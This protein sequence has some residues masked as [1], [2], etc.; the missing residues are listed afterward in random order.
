MWV[1]ISLVSFLLA[2]GAIATAFRR[3]GSY[4][5]FADELDRRWGFLL[6][7]DQDASAAVAPVW[8]GEF[9]TDQNDA[10]WLNMMRY[11]RERSLDFAYWPLN[12]EK[13]TNEGETYGLLMED[14]RSVRHTWKLKA[15]QALIT[16]P[17][18]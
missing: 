17:P 4:A 3:L 10:W 11:A 15:M 18:H 5:V 8:L 12:G 9:G 13:R 7:G 14:S 16:A 1:A 2:F 6:A